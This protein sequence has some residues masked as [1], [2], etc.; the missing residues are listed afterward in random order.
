MVRRHL[1]SLQPVSKGGEIV[2]RRLGSQLA[3]LGPSNTQL[4]QGGLY[5]GYPLLD[6]GDSVGEWSRDSV[7]CIKTLSNSLFSTL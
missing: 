5:N 2:N 1:Y 6:H 3:S 7:R 4:C